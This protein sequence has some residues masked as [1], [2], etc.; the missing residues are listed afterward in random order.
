MSVAS[1]TELKVRSK[2]VVS[3]LVIF[4]LKSM[5]QAKTV[6]PNREEEELRSAVYERNDNAFAGNEGTR[7]LDTKTYNSRFG[8]RCIEIAWDRTSNRF[9]GRSEVFRF[10]KNC[11]AVSASR[12]PTHPKTSADANA[13]R[14]GLRITSTEYT[15]CLNPFLYF[16]AGLRCAYVIVHDANHG[17]MR[18]GPWRRRFGLRPTSL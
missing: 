7:K 1:V 12:R 17:T 5:L 4:G 15:G 6:D 14:L 16:F 18:R 11:V 13:L 8:G 10:R 2:A 3:C 9:A